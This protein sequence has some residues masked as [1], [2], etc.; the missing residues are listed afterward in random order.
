MKKTTKTEMLDL[1]V[2]DIWELCNKPHRFFNSLKE[3]TDLF[4]KN[5]ETMN[6]IALAGNKKDTLR[7]IDRLEKAFRKTYYNN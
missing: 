7:E 2:H 3:A 5:N 4:H 6:A 1:I